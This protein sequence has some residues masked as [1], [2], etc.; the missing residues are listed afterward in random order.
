[1]PTHKRSRTRGGP[2]PLVIRNLSGLA[3]LLTNI[4]VRPPGRLD[5]GPR[6]GLIFAG[7]TGHAC[8]FGSYRKSETV[9]EI[10]A[11]IADGGCLPAPD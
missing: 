5:P 8:V 6:D 4:V 1:M 10:G 9:V 2:A 11:P 3:R 7:W